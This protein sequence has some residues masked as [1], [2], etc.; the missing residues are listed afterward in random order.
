ML[1]SY[2][3]REF[4]KSIPRLKSSSSRARLADIDWD[5]EAGS[6]DGNDAMEI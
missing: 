1:A 2:H 5:K 6:K 4:A 3:A